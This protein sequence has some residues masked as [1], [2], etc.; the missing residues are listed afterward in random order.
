MSINLEDSNVSSGFLDA[1][2]FGL[3]SQIRYL[4]DRETLLSHYDEFMA[5]NHLLGYLVSLP[6]QVFLLPDG[7]PTSPSSDEDED[8]LPDL[9]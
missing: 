3:A 5:T 8:T 9:D 1:L 2:L 4:E 7:T 6:G